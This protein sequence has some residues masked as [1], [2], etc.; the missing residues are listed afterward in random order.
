MLK[1]TETLALVYSIESTPREL[2]NEY[3]HDRVSMV[4]KHLWVVVH[5]TKVVYALE[6]LTGHV[7]AYFTAA[8]WL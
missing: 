4:L 3:Q 5:L 8:P 6:R 2:S 1:L 7:R